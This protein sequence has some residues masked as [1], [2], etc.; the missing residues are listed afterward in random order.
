MGT[1]GREAGRWTW[2]LRP[3]CAGSPEITLSDPTRRVD[4]PLPEPHGRAPGSRTDGEERS[5]PLPARPRVG[6]GAVPTR[7]RGWGGNPR[8]QARPA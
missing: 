3:R 1:V 2:A 4:A 6:A 8:P 7:P 5:R